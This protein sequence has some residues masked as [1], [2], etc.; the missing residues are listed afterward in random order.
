MKEFFILLFMLA[1]FNFSVAQKGPN[2][3][4]ISNAHLMRPTVEKKG[5]VHTPI[6]PGGPPGPKPN[7]PIDGGLFWLVASGIAFGV[8]RFFKK[9]SLHLER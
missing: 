4:P 7:V 6:N 1:T 8:S 3:E 9:H 2:T 5:N